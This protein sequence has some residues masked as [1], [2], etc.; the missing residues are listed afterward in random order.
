[1]ITPQYF[2][3]FSLKLL[4]IEAQPSKSFKLLESYS[5]PQYFYHSTPNETG[6]RKEVFNANSK[7]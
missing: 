4:K 6:A 5:P 7:S 3:Y 1:M 2:D